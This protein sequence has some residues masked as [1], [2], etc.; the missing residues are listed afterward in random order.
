MRRILAGL[1][2]A[3]IQKSLAPALHEDACAA[4]GMHGLYH[5][6]DLDALPGR[7]LKSLLDAVR[8]AGFAGVNVTYP[9]KEAVVPLLD[10][11]SAEARQIGAVNTVTIDPTGRTTGHNTDRI[12]FGRAFEEALGRDAIRGKAAMLVGAGGAGRA[13]AFALLDLGAEALLIHDVDAD[14]AGRLSRDV[15]SVVGSGRCRAVSDIRSAIAAAV[16]VVNATPV[17]MLGIPGL[18]I[19]PDLVAPG[20]WV[21]DVIYTP[22]E[23]DLIKAARARG[24]RVMGGAGMCVH[25]AVETFRLFTG[26]S[27]DLDRMQRAFVEAAAIR[28]K[29]LAQAG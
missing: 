23:T 7:T 14:R 8:T 13:V 2:G 6:M 18:P 26:V 22:L 15:S 4:A 1:I 28:E 12:G 29:G 21:A 3:N 25:Q 20:Q 27:P 10:E 11:V 19:A 5:L 9:C 17:G 16:G 24:C